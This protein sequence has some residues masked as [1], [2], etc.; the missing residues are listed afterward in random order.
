MK[1]WIFKLPVI[2]IS[3]RIKCFTLTW[4]FSFWGMFNITLW[5]LFRVPYNVVS[6]TWTKLTA[7]CIVRYEFEFFLLTKQTYSIFRCLFLRCILDIFW[8]IHLKHLKCKAFEVDWARFLRI[9]HLVV[10]CFSIQAGI[11]IGKISQNITIVRFYDINAR[12]FN[13]R[14]IKPLD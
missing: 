3:C 5:F 6:I 4:T 2:L 7:E 14:A 13:T 1:N 8:T 9:L 11:Y 12:I 10:R